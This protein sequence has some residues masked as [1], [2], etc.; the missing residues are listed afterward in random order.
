MKLISHLLTCQN[1]FSLSY[2]ANRAH[3]CP[4][5]PCDDFL[6]LVF[7]MAQSSSI[8]QG[9]A[10]LTCSLHSQIST[11]LRSPLRV[12]LTS[13]FVAST[14]GKMNW[15][16]MMVIYTLAALIQLITMHFNTSIANPFRKHS[17]MPTYKNWSCM[18]TLH[19]RADIFLMPVVKI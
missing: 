13:W 15:S 2:R 14:S 18:F 19:V 5:V 7:P 17:M 6:T 12:Y 8:L 1:A 11:F 9:K 3:T 16:Q 10:F 4:F